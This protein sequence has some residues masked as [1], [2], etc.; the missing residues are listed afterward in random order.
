MITLIRPQI[1]YSLTTA[2]RPRYSHKIKGFAY[3]GL[4]LNQE[5]I[6]HRAYYL[7]VI[8]AWTGLC[9]DCFLKSNVRFGSFN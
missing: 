5:S 1:D 8:T 2:E 3:K 6:E 7:V 9:R 4:D